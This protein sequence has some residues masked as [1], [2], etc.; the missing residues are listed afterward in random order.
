[1]IHFPNLWAQRLVDV[2][3]FLDLLFEGPNSHGVCHGDGEGVVVCEVL[4]NCFEVG[5]PEEETAS[6]VVGLEGGGI[7]D[8]VVVQEQQF[9]LFLC[10]VLDFFKI[11]ESEI[12]V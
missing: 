8:E 12:V 11:F 6:G 10:V 3:H 7:E 1:M 9:I 5:I 2:Y 4:V